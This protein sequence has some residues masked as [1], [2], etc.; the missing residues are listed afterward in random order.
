MSRDAVLARIHAALKASP[1]DV[2]R[3][4]AVAARLG[5]PHP[6]LVPARTAVS[7]PERVALFKEFLAAQGT[8]VIAVPDREHIPA[9]LATYLLAHALPLRLRKGSDPYL[10]GLP[11]ESAPD[12]VLVA[13][14]A[15][16]C[17]SAGLS[18]ALA[19]VAETG[20]LVLASGP[21]NPVTL[22]FVPDTHIVVVSAQTIVGGYEAACRLVEAELGSAALPRTLNFISGASRT[23]DIGGKIV[24]GAH[25]PRRL[26]VVVVGTA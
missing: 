20:T 15:Q 24:L 13:G 21:G 17:D 22:A 5:D 23:G 9:A 16:P 18:R 10:A 26:A 19:G 25:G 7:E 3:A 1:G 4:R 6:L 8:D 2:R 14:P 11:W 12:L